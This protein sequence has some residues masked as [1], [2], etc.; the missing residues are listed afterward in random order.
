M[1]G[2]GKPTQILK[3][4]ASNSGRVP[5]TI[6]VKPEDPKNKTEIVKAIAGSIKAGI[7]VIARSRASRSRGSAMPW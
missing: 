4:Y 1:S 5:E 7:P 3:D 6:S 2:A